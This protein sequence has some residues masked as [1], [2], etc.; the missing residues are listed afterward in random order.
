MFTSFARC[1]DVHAVSLRFLLCFFVFYIRW[2]RVS[3]VEKYDM[4]QSQS[5]SA[6]GR[7]HAT[8]WVV[9]RCLYDFVRVLSFNV[10]NQTGRADGTREVPPPPPQFTAM[11]CFTYSLLWMSSMFTSHPGRDSPNHFLFTSQDKAQGTR[12]FSHTVIGKLAEVLPELMGGSAD[13]TGS[14][15]TDFK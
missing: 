3:P 10:L 5:T 13:L 2:H 11:A 7:K 9:A 14:N 6:T 4:N 1:C 8:A 15:N 12:K